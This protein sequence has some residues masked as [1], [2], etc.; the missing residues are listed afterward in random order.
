MKPYNSTQK[1]LWKMSMLL[2]PLLLAVSQ[3][4]WSGGV[5]TATAGVLQILSF[6]FWI[7]AFQGMFEQ[8]KD[9][10]PNYAVWGFFLAVL[11][12]LAGNNFGIDGIYNDAFR[13]YIADPTAKFDAKSGTPGFIAFFLG[14]ALAPLSWLILGILL[15]LK[16]KIPAWLGVM[17]VIAA[18]GFPLSR[19]PRL[20]WLAHIDNMLLLFSMVVMAF[21]LF[22]AKE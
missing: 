6:L 20:P 13:N 8:I 9:A 10:Y 14:G 7:F 1:N 2:A 12:C 11:G 15:T 3:F 4:F 16:K 18:V 21:T 22:K 19:I 17:L 5:L